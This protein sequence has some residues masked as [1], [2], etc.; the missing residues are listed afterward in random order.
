MPFFRVLMRVTA[1]DGSPVLGDGLDA[2]MYR[3]AWCAT[4]ESARDLAL[5]NA[6]RQQEVQHLRARQSS[7]TPLRFDVVS[8]TP[9]SFWDWLTCGYG[10]LLMHDRAGNLRL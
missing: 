6:G 2:Y 8:V 3:K 4:E 7:M 10:G 9:I 5:R 1:G